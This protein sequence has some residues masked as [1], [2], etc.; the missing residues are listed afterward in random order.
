MTHAMSPRPPLRL[1]D[2]L[3]SFLGVTMVMGVGSNIL[4]FRIVSGTGVRVQGEGVGV[5]V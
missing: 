4:G 3:L 5:W 2:P 1:T